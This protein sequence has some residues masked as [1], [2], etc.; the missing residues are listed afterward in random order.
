MW[1]KMAGFSRPPSPDDWCRGSDVMCCGPGVCAVV[2]CLRELVTG[3]LRVQ[4]LFCALVLRLV[5]D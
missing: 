5:N 2:S 3:G 4:L 1:L